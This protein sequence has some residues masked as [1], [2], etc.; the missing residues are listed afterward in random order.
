MRKHIILIGYKSV[1]K[2]EVGKKLARKLGA[3]FFD[4]DL[5]L[6]KLY[7]EQTGKQLS[8][9]AIFLK[10]GAR[11]FRNLEHIAL[12]AALKKRPAVIALGGGTVFSPRNRRLLKGLRLVHLT[13][14]TENFLK[15]ISAKGRPA[16]F[17]KGYGDFQ[18]RLDSAEKIYRRL[19]YKTLRCSP[20][21]AET[22]DTIITRFRLKNRR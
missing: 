12:K 14:S 6:E 22:A 13:D 10:R 17:K 20:T 2:T 5:L 16:F 3:D 15:K 7:S 9:R 18:K 8:Y 1:G 19:A 21:L 11:F 4:T